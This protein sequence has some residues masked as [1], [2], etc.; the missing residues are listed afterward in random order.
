MKPL[1]LPLAITA[2]ALLLAS[3]THAATVIWDAPT[4]I[5]TSS[6]Q[7]RT[8]GT[9]FAAWS[10]GMGTLNTTTTVVSNGVTFQ[11]SLSPNSPGG[12]PGGNAGS[13]MN[14]TAAISWTNARAYDQPPIVGTPYA[15]TDADYQTILGGTI[16]QANAANTLTL[17]ISGLTAGQTYLFQGWVEWQ[18]LVTYTETFSIG[19]IT[20]A[21]I[22][23]NVGNV[24]GGLGQFIT[25]YVTMGAAETSF[26]LNIAG[27]DYKSINALQL[28]AVPEPGA[29][30]LAS[31]GLGA[32]LLLRRRRALR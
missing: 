31:L 27:S 26:A 7:V 10:W 17:T 14:G 19:G 16:Y 1:A 4:N 25:G 28:R 21:S 18:S 15:G 9:L 30:A 32:I 13:M 24:N 23:P 29:I 22:D 11:K 5:S 2:S 12:N 20:S 6:S 8:D 3:P